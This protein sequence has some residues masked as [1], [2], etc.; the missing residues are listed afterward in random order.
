MMA[1]AAVAA[2]A[3]AWAKGTISTFRRPEEDCPPSRIHMVIWTET[4][5]LHVR[6][7]YSDPNKTSDVTSLR[8]KT[9]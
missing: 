2:V 3:V 6:C 9:E 5:T 8:E 7:Q 1:R 4:I